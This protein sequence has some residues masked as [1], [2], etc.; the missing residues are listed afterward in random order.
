M[1]LAGCG[2]KGPDVNLVEGVVTLDGTPVEGANVNFAPKQEPAPG[3]I[4]GPLLAGGATDAN[5]KYTLSVIR[6]GAIGG[7][8]TAG[9]YNVSIVKKRV[10]NAP[11][12]PNQPMVGPPKFEYDI[13]QVFERASKITAEVVKGKNT[14]NFVLKS[15]GTF[16]V[17]K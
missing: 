8:T 12:A 1:L 3:D 10:T 14:I 15:D 5:G 17:T 4:S 2:P 11:T 13:P 6:G 7:G 9:E 16:E